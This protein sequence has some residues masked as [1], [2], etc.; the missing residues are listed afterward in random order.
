MKE[1]FCLIT[2][3]MAVIFSGGCKKN[4]STGA[5]VPDLASA[6]ITWA[7][8]TNFKLDFKDENSQIEQMKMMDKE[9]VQIILD[10]VENGKLQAWD[11]TT[12]E[13]LS[14]EKIQNIY[15]KKDTVVI[16]DPVSFEETRK[17]IE[18]DLDR[19]KV[20]KLRIKQEW[21]WDNKAM[22]LQS[23]LL[24]AAPLLEVYGPD[25]NYR[26]D[27]PLYMVYFGGNGPNKK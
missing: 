24:G 26:G 1:I 21:Y 12:G 27:L 11:Y 17:A 15:H 3:F 2:I 13:P 7:K 23:R 10:N 19:D 18:N 6:D 22:Q 20:N 9:L 14:Q 16:T 25:D 5:A 8:K 4:A